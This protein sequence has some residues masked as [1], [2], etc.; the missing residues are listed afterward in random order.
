LTSRNFSSSSLLASFFVNSS[1]WA[2]HTAF[3]FF[4]AASSP[5]KNHQNFCIL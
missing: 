4:S 2:L 1:H 5:L 3:V